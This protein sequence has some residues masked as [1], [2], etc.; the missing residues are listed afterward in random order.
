MVTV[1]TNKTQSAG[2]SNV[3]Q[4]ILKLYATELAEN[5]L[6]ELKMQL[7]QYYA[8]KAIQAADKIW[9]EK[10]YSTEEMDNW[11]NE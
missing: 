5:E 11:L 6:H 2:L 4:E 7:A 1:Q 8:Q 3:Q 10:S 9:D